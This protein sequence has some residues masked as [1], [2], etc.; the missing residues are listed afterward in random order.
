M[1]NTPAK[2][3]WQISSARLIEIEG[4]I[5][6]PRGMILLPPEPLAWPE[7]DPGDT[8]DYVFEI[9]P[10]LTGNAGDSIATLDVAISPNNPGDLTMLSAAADGTRAILWLQAGQ[11]GTLYTVTVTITTTGGRALARSIAL[12]VVALASVPAPASAITTLDGAPITS[13]YGAPITAT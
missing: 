11:S 9:A 3:I 4:F 8:L 5:P 6:T 7:K 1:M 10:A 12:P 2:P 13:P